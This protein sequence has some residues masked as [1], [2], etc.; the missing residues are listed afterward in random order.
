MASSLGK[1]CAMKSRG[2]EPKVSPNSQLGREELRAS[3]LC[4]RYHCTFFLA[5]FGSNVWPFNVIK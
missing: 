5:K 4:L 2:T 3:H 1:D